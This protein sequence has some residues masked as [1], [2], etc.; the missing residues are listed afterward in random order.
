L[1]IRF[2]SD[3]KIQSV[4]LLSFFPARANNLDRNC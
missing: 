1:A 2:H 4:N 3:A